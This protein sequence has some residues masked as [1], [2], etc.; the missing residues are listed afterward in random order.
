LKLFYLILLIAVNL[1]SQETKLDSDKAPNPVETKKEETTKKDKFFFTF[2]NAWTTY[3]PVEARN[4]VDEN[5][6]YGIGSGDD[7]AVVKETTRGNTSQINPFSFTYFNSNQ[8]LFF[9]FSRY[10]LNLDALY[11]NPTSVNRPF[12]PPSGS[13]RELPN[14]R[15]EE[16][17]FDIYKSFSISESNIIFYGLG[18]RNILKSAN[19][20]EFSPFNAETI[21]RYNTSGLSFY[22]KY[23]FKFAENWRFTFFLQ[24]FYTYGAK[25]NQD[26]FLVLN[27]KYGTVDGRPY[28]YYSQSLRE[29]NQK[30]TFYGSELDI[31]LS[32]Q[33]NDNL[34]LSFGGNL[35]YTK[36]KYKNNRHLNLA[37]DERGRLFQSADN[38]FYLLE[39]RL[40]NRYFT[41][42]L[43]YS[44]YLGINAIF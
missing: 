29:E 19:Q 38:S 11:Q 1:F 25:N 17:K 9:E 8:N 35:I 31:S 10:R 37:F 22:F 5:N 24:P 4:I 30:A 7:T 32:Y 18:Y 14:I 2:K 6:F 26:P 34:S 41:T 40:S 36:I 23:I 33:I 28:R 13:N 16:N 15:R 27:S 21:E 12:P 43:L 44:Y 42:E 3:F 20:R 39:Q